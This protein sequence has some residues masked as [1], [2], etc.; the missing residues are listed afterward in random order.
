MTDADMLNGWAS[1]AKRLGI[2][3]ENTAIAYARLP[4]DPLPVRVIMGE[5]R[6]KA[7]HLDEWRARRNGGVLP[8]GTELERLE[9]I[10]AVASFLGVDRSTVFRLARRPVDRLP[11]L[12]KRE[13]RWA[14]RSA[15]RDFLMRHDVPFQV[16]DR[17]RAA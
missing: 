10:D 5:P 17:S 14:Y 6:V 16:L 7:R 11:L 2:G 8:D 9:G 12:G 1:I 4:E 3:S 15:L 13:A